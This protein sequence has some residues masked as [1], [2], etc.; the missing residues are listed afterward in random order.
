MGDKESISVSVD[1]DLKGNDEGELETITLEDVKKID[2]PNNIKIKLGFSEIELE[3]EGKR[4]QGRNDINNHIWYV[5]KITSDSKRLDP[6][7]KINLTTY[8]I[9]KARITKGSKILGEKVSQNAVDNV[10][11]VGVS[12]AERPHVD[13]NTGN[14]HLN[15][16][17][18]SD[19]KNNNEWQLVLCKDGGPKA[20]KP[21][22]D[23]RQ[24]YE[25]TCSN[26]NHKESC[27][28]HKACYYPLIDDEKS[29]RE[30]WRYEFL[31][32]VAEKI[33]EANKILT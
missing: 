31:A 32:K 2:P 7:N 5:Y 25:Y 15:D 16:N 27:F 13:F 10:L 33:N 8:R 14:I 17:G 19:S 3:L 26:K 18:I 22:E 30:N 23:E 29:L 24:Y 28:V 1:K 21:E 6:Y 4:R 20:K 12:T 11:D 9:T